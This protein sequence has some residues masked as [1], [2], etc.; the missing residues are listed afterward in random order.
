M[1][2]RFALIACALVAA[3]GAT[4]ARQSDLDELMGRVLLKRDDN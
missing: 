3:A 1:I 4:A 2:R